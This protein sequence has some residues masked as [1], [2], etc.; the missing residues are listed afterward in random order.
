M[1]ASAVLGFAAALAFAG[2]SLCLG[3]LLTR[4]GHPFAGA[5][6]AS[7]GVIFASADVVS[8]AAL[9]VAVEAADRGLGSSVFAAFGDLHT[10]ALLLALAPSGIVLL[11][12]YRAGFG[13]ILSWAGIVI[14]LGC[15]VAAGAV[16]S[17]D[18]DRGPLGAAVVLWFL[19]LPLWLVAASIVL[20]RR[21]ETAI[22]T[23]FD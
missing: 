22:G 21:R 5:A 16:M 19:G 1:R 13:R 18:F 7:G 3:L 11:A 20:V 23:I 12:A 17:E 8:S 15:I 2:F 14:G 10:A 6:A 9:V 4:T